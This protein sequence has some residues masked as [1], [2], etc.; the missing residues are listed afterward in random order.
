MNRMR[1]NRLGDFWLAKRPD[2]PNFYICW[3]D[4]KRGKVAMRSTGTSILTEAEDRLAEMFKKRQQLVQED[5]QDVPLMT[6]LDRYYDQHAST[7][8][9]KNAAKY[10]IRVLRKHCAD[11][12]VS[13]FR[14]PQQR[15]VA[16]ALRDGGASEG[17]ISRVM[18]V[19]RAALLRAF[20]DEELRSIPKFIKLERGETRDRVLSLEESA[21]L[22]NAANG[23]AQFLYLLLAFGTGARPSAVLELTRSQ[24]DFRRGL[25][26]LNP[27][28]RRQTKKRRPVVPLPSTLVPWLKN[29]DAEHFINYDGRAYTKWGWDAIF[30][31]LMKR[32]GVK[33]ASAY[34]IRHT[35]ATELYSRGVSYGDVQMFLGHSMES[36]GTTGRYIHLRPDYLQ[37][38]RL[39]I[40]AFFRELNPL[41]TRPICDIELEVQPDPALASN[42]KALEAQPLPADLHHRYTTT[43][44]MSSE[45]K[46]A[47][48]LNY[49]VGVTRFVVCRW[50]RWMRV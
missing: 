44:L 35:V 23:D 2:R 20:D 29:G 37:A 22:F 36:M 6:I 11:L 9:S 30:K 19:A 4:K 16:K 39:A 45:P 12:S 13:E 15:A 27:S 1:S 31:R 26:Q 43:E 42:D 17:H 25:L 24:I 41:L 34:T 32:S 48:V 46:V 47:N 40:D 5:P 18:S 10:A 50:S 7:L 3:M 33:N 49:L 38:P 14:K 8:P 28:G 21:A